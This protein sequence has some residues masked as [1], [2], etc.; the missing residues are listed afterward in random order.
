MC[1]LNNKHDFKSL[2]R[3]LLLSE[4]A[5]AQLMH[6]EETWTDF[7][8]SDHIYHISEVMTVH[9]HLARTHS[10]TSFK[11]YIPPILGFIFREQSNIKKFI[12]LLRMDPILSLHTP[13]H[14]ISYKKS[15]W[16][17]A[18]MYLWEGVEYVCRVFKQTFDF[19]ISNEIDLS[20]VFFRVVWYEQQQQQQ[21]DHN[22][23]IKI[24]N[25]SSRR[26]VLIDWFN[27]TD[28]SSSARTAQLYYMAD[29]IRCFRIHKNQ[30]NRKVYSAEN[31]Q[32]R[33]AKL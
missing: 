16:K 33:M 5:H 23:T 31:T 22:S 30:T 2:I 17:Y 12:L 1:Y 6:G 8:C 24:N 20:N 7:N 19:E 4:W 10:R 21:Q 14:L 13:K 28:D 32:K 11:I 29:Q 27:A 3:N 18:S 15:V 26:I 9:T 25:Q